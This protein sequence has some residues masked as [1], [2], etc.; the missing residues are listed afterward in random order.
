MQYMNIEQITINNYSLEKYTLAFKVS[1]YHLLK[2]KGAVKLTIQ[3]IDNAG[4]PVYETGKRLDANGQ[5]ITIS[6]A[7]P[8]IHKGYFKLA[9]TAMDL[10]TKKSSELKKYIKLN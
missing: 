8:D 5:S 2:G 7:L 1:D 10:L 3:L 4:T 6:L 9:I